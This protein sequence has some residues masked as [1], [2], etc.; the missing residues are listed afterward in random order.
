MNIAAVPKNEGLEYFLSEFI[1]ARVFRNRK[2]IG[3]LL[4]KG[5]ASK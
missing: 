3:K 4:E 5:D 1:G 2:K